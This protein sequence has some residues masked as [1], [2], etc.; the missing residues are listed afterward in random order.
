MTPLKV[1]GGENDTILTYNLD[2]D[3][4]RDFQ[5]QNILFQDPEEFKNT[6]PGFDHENVDNR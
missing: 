6:P 4:L 2:I 1:K 5:K 3:K